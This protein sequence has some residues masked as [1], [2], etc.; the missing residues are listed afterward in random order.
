MLLTGKIPLKLRLTLVCLVLLLSVLIHFNGIDSGT[1]AFLHS[2]GLIGAAITGAFYTFGVTTPFAIIF[3][4]E[5]MNSN[6]A[7]LIALIAALTAASFDVVLFNL[8][9]KELEKNAGKQLKKIRK[10]IGNH[11]I[12]LS[13]LGFFL[14][15]SPFPDELA[16]AFMEITKIKP[17]KIWV[18]IFAAKFVTLMLAYTALNLT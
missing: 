14:F 11:N 18:T 3:L 1:A 5:M 16:L 9:K 17:I 4:L 13:A 2:L 12:F 8:V 15:G 7:V 10:K 6:N